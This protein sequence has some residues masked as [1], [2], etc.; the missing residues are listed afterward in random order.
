M[1]K[2][3]GAHTMN[4]R[5]SEKATKYVGLHPFKLHL[6]PSEITWGEPMAAMKSDDDGS[7]FPRKDI[8]KL[9]SEIA[10]LREKLEKAERTREKTE[11]GM[12]DAKSVVVEIHRELATAHAENRALQLEG[13]R[14]KREVENICSIYEL[15]ANPNIQDICMRLQDIYSSSPSAFAEEWKKALGNIIWDHLESACFNAMLERSHAARKLHA[16][17]N[18]LEGKE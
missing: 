15:S 16:L 11:R 3:N 4:T 13:E 17:L 12:E 5:A 14:A 1:E 18:R 2:G 8:D 7:W 6:V 9:L 10:D